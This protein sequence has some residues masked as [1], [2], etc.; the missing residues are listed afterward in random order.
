M[1]KWAG[2]LPGEETVTYFEMNLQT[3]NKNYI[4]KKITSMYTSCSKHSHSL[5]CEYAHMHRIYD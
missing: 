3:Y 1:E 2:I 5:G 4:K